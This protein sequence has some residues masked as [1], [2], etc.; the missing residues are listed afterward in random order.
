MINQVYNY[1]SANLQNKPFPILYNPS[2]GSQISGG[3]GPGVGAMFAPL[4]LKVGKKSISTTG[5]GGSTSKKSSTGAIVGGVVGGVVGAVLLGG[6]AFFLWRRR[7]RTTGRY[8]KGYEDPDRIQPIRVKP[9]NLPSDPALD[10]LSETNYTGMHELRA[11]P[12]QFG[13][14]PTGGSAG[15]GSVAG[16]TSDLPNPYPTTIVSASGASSSGVG[17]VN[18]LYRG[19]MVINNLGDNE[20]DRNDVAYAAILAAQS[21]MANSS[22]G[23]SNPKAAMRQDELRNEVDDLRRE[24]E[25]MK[26]ERQTLGEAPP[27][28]EE[29]L[30]Y[31]NA[32][33]KQNYQ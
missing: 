30:R 26:E 5:V 33:A 12:F 29:E 6:L 8:N 19:P 23:T 25:R 11:S 22:A 7:E 32:L 3:A 10:S 20:A 18:A 21:N 4:A 14:V 13:A 28:Y 27:S 16:S 17:G 1:V 9:V 24:I 31:A 15:P 2:S